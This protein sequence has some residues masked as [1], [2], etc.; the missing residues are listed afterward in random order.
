MK[1]GLEEVVSFVN[2]SLKTTSHTTNYISGVSTDTRKINKGDL[3]IPL[4]GDRFNGHA[5]LEEAE[6]QGAVAA[7]WQKDQPLID[8]VSIP[9]IFVSD[10]LLALQNL[11]Q[12][13]REQINPTVVAIT[14]SN[15]KTTTKDLVSAIL[16]T[17][18]RIHK[19][20]GNLNNH[21]GVPLTL[22]SMPEDTEIAIVEM[23]MSNFGE[24]ERLSEIAR[25]DI[26]LITN[27]GES[28]LEYLK[29]RENIAKAKLEILKGLK[30]DGTLILNGDEPLL[31]KQLDI[32]LLDY[33]IRWMG[34]ESSNNVYASDI[35]LNSEQ[36]KFK[37]NDGVSFDLPLLGMHNVLNSLM[38]IEVGK[39]M[40]VT[41]SNIKEGLKAPKLTGMRLQQMRAKNGA[42]ILN[43]AYN[44]SPTSMRAALSLLNSLNNTKKV[45]VLGDMLELGNDSKHFHHE[46]GIYCAELEIDLLIT[47][48]KLGGWIARGASEHGMLQENIYNI[49]KIENIPSLLR[50]LTD[51]DTVILVKGSRGVHLET[52][53]N[54][55][56]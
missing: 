21:I 30:I 43:D 49:D 22:L 7:L 54:Q 36:I 50:Q 10:T 14:G 33:Q 35:E 28:H 48:G 53:V 47:T 27:I 24:I 2:G 23:G 17:S 20:E 11:S 41:M 37:T 38:A 45:A 3:F 25:P 12:R 1:L 13:Y 56:I 16:A 5:F 26:A 39:L 6:Q 44:A 32:T 18:F 9:I 51:N 34:I 52:V 55:L 40:N 8:R 42:L 19:T 4:V 46:I 15:G 29:S 31:R